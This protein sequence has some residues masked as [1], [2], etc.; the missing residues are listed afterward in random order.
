MHKARKYG[1]FCTKK[2]LETA[3]LCDLGA[4]SNRR[5][6]MFSHY[7][8]HLSVNLCNAVTSGLSELISAADAA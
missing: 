1:L 4:I 7:L 5:G 8:E 6:R 2:I 3:R